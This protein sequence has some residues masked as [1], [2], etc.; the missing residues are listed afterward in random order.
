MSQKA[1]M[2]PVSMSLRCCGGGRFSFVVPR[3]AAA[4]GAHG[5]GRVWPRRR[6]CGGGGAAAAVGAAGLGT[7]PRPHRA[8]KGQQKLKGT[9]L[10][11]LPAHGVDLLLQAGD[12]R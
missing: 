12:R 10:G 4:A 3:A 2:S 5:R 6:W 9:H 7:A 11:E 8:G 1:S